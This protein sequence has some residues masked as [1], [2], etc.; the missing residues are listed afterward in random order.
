MDVTKRFCH[1]RHKRHKRGRR[2]LMKATKAVGSSAEDHDEIAARRAAPLP[3]REVPS[4]K[5]V[6][7]S[8]DD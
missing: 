6:G 2:G 4:T 7:T 3:G 1:K 5:L 8:A